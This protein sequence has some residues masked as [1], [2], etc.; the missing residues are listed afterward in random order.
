MDGCRT[1]VSLLSQ[2]QAGYLLFVVCCDTCT[3]LVPRHLSLFTQFIQHSHFARLFTV[4]GR[5]PRATHTLLTSNE[6]VQ[7][8]RGAIV[9]LTR[10]VLP[11]FR[12]LVFSPQLTLSLQYAQMPRAR[13]RSLRRIL[14]RTRRKIKVGAPCVHHV[15]CVQLFTS[16]I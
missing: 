2:R 1:D 5:T 9:T 8:L 4:S 12:A 15:T 6:Y 16:E 3:F 13:R 11:L 7:V 14:T 10:D